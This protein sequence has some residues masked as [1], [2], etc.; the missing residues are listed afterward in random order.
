MLGRE[1]TA[2]SD[3]EEYKIKLSRMDLQILSIIKSYP[4][5]Y[6]KISNEPERKIK[7]LNNNINS[8]L[9]EW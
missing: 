5:L 8:I 9:P 7:Y 1:V 3:D 2:V 4:K 6:K